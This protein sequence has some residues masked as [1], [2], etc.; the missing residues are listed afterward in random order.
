MK[1]I[2]E[3][4]KPNYGFIRGS[5]GIPRFFIPSG[6]RLTILNKLW[7]DL[8]EGM[9]V[10]FSHTDHPRGPRAIN[11]MVVDDGQAAIPEDM[12]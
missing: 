2:I 10:E 7:D 12:Q 3:T 4:M 1:G 9:V 11:V 5:D 6:M 8:K